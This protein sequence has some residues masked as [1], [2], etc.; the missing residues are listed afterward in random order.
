[1]VNVR[2]L[3]RK[4]KH[5]GVFTMSLCFIPTTML[6]GLF[7]TLAHHHPP[8]GHTHKC[9]GQSLNPEGL[10]A[11][12]SLHSP[13]LSPSTGI[14]LPPLFSSNWTSSLLL[15][16][17]LEM[18]VLEMS[19]LAGWRVS[20]GIFILLFYFILSY[21]LVFLSNFRAAPVA[22]GSSQARGL[23][24]VTAAGLQNSHSN[25]RSELHLQPISQLMAVLDP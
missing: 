16:Y 25:A 9:Y 6:L 22:Y 14:Q 17:S 18:T 19:W 5:Y 3:S 12:C 20:K 2:N 24:R 13:Q 4:V 1:M 7:K 11:R 23:I 10:Q 21:F 8:R 15:S